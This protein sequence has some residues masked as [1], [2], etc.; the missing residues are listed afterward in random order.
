[1]HVN[2]VTV[3]VVPRSVVVKASRLV[4]AAHES[5][6]FV[7]LEV[8]LD[9]LV[10]T[11]MREMNENGKVLSVPFTSLLAPSNLVPT[12]SSPGKCCQVCPYVLPTKPLN[13]DL[14]RRKFEKHLVCPCCASSSS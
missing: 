8:I 1:M 10:Q 14:G 5:L 12:P 2:V 13:S 9:H 3:V 6:L 11:G 4:H 7:G